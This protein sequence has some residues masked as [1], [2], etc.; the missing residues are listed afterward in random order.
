M[1]KLSLGILTAV[2]LFFGVNQQASAQVETGSIVIDTYY[3]FPNFGKSLFNAIANDPSTVNSRV[4]GIGPLGLRFE[5]MIADKVG[6]G[7]DFNYL[8]NGFEYDYTASVYNPTTD[9]FEDRTYTA[10][11]K[12]T[13]LRIMAR[14]N[15]HFV[16]TEQVD[17]YVGFGAGYKQRINSFTS[18]N[19]EDVEDELETS[20]QLVPFSARICIGTRFF[21]TDMVGLNLE[22]GAGGGPLLS[23]GLSLK[24]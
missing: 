17:T 11:Y 24:F 18:T 10:T 4:T 21:L 7:A 13:K 5:Y 23:G 1:K 20:L 12:K 16:Q 19:P 22:L 9:S 14:L 6:V 8:T 2:A 15:Y 3:G